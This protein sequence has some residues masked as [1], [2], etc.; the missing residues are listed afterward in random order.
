MKNRSRLI[1]TLVF[2]IFLAS[3]SRSDLAGKRVFFGTPDG[4][5]ERLA[6]EIHKAGGIPVSVPLIETVIL[7]TNPGIDSLL[8]H[9]AEIDYIAFS[10]RKAIEAFISR[11][12]SATIEYLRTGNIRLCAI[13]K[14]AELL[15]DE[16]GLITYIE[17]EEP[18]PRGIINELSEIKDIKGK[19]IAVITPSVRDIPEPDVVPDFI[20]GLKEIGMDVIRVDAY[21]TG[22]VKDLDFEKYRYDLAEGYYD[23]IAFTSTAEIEVFLL[24][25]DDQTLADDQVIACFG[26]YT[27]SNARN[28]GLDVDIVAGDFSSFAGFADAIDEYFTGRQ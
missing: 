6:V 22:P 1:L 26:P 21:Y 20:E 17:P 9:L 10:S 27:A 25:M 12:D 19:S 3:C 4:Y 18:S 8:K 24:M 11:A 23:V 15:K 13:G 2:F 16:I 28:M 7:D 14:D 5:A